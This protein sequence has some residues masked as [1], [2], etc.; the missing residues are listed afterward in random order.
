MS[1]AVLEGLTIVFL[2]GGMCV[3]LDGSASTAQQLI[4]A[5]VTVAALI[6]AVVLGARRH[7]DLGPD[8]CVLHGLRFDEDGCPG[9]RAMQ[10]PPR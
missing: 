3:T 1:R 4:G 8:H 7:R 5:A 2:I 6:G 10:E 9:C